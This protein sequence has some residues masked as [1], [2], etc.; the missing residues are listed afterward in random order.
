MNTIIHPTAVIED[1]AIIGSNCIIGPHCHI[2]SN[3][4]IGDYNTLHSHAVI[5]NSTT[6]GS[7]NEI[8]PFVCLGTRTEDLKYIKGSSTKVSIGDGNIFREYCTVN[9]GTADGSMTSIKNN[10][11]FL[12]HSHVA[13][14]CYIGEKVLIRLWC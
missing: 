2:D 13:H 7:Y 14:D 3:V 6:I 4:K 9:S 5:A 12:S 8:F 10:C 11:T 1:G